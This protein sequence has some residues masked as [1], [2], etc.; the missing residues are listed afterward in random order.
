MDKDEVVSPNSP[1]GQ[2]AATE[3]EDEALLRTRLVAELRSRFRHPNTARHARPIL[4]H[5]RVKRDAEFWELLTR[6]SELSTQDW[7]EIFRQAAALG[8]LQLHL[9][10]GEPARSGGVRPG[11]GAARR[12]HPHRRAPAVAIGRLRR[13]RRA[14]SVALAPWRVVSDIPRP[15]KLP[16][17]GT[18][19][20]TRTSLGIVSSWPG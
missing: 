6:D 9:S 20:Y 2:Q 13:L 15:M 12:A 18:P 19:T 14:G 11:A 7:A 3:A 16:S 5:D 8:V 1:N 17:V 10:G 4:R